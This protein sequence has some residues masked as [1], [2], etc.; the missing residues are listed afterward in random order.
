M[1]IKVQRD[2]WIF[3]LFPAVGFSIGIIA[4]CYGGAIAFLVFPWSMVVNLVTSRMRCPHCQRPVGQR[5]TQ[6]WGRRFTWWSPFTPR[7]CAHCGRAVTE[8]AI[9]SG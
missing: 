8:E 1:S 6:M 3:I 7:F 9:R 2:V 5:T 4:A